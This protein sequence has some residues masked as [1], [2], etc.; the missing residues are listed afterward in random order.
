MQYK[1]RYEVFDPTNIKTYPVK[2]R[3][4]KVKYS[5]LRT[6]D[7]VLNSVIDLPGKVKKEID[8]LALEIVQRHAKVS[9]FFYLRVDIW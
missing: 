9:Q 1:G 4:N 3:N 6:I 5:D 2:G 8:D 7:E